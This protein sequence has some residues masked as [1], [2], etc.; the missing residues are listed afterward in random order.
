MNS[1]ILHSNIFALTCFAAACAFI[2][3][4]VVGMGAAASVSSGLRKGDE[5]FAIE[6]TRATRLGGG[7]F[8]AV[9][10]ATWHG[11]R[12]AAKTFHQ[13][14]DPLRMGIDTQE[15]LDEVVSNIKFEV[16]AMYELAHPNIVALKD[17]IA[18]DCMGLDVPMWIV[19]EL[20]DGE[21]YEG[22]WRDDKRHGRGVHTR[23]DGERYEGGVSQI[24]QF[25]SSLILN[26]RSASSASLH[27]AVAPSAAPPQSAPTAPRPPRVAPPPRH[28]SAAL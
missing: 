10:E 12:V 11:E 13:L 19:M 17:V 8:G 15:Q 16:A 3:Y 24:L 18:G 2:R 27:A 23:A 25:H 21:Q 7:Q 4:R 6:Q 20:C 14:R 22:G 1:Q 5:A 9:F 28:R 26:P